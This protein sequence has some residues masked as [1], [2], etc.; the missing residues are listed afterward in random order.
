MHRFMVKLALVASMVFIEMP[1]WQKVEQSDHTWNG[2]IIE[3]GL[4]EYIMHHFSAVRAKPSK[5]RP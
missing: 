2:R 4:L 3:G 1:P 5:E